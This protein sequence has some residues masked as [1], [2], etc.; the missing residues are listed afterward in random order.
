M[1]GARILGTYLMIKLADGNSF[2]RP[3]GAAAQQ[4]F[5]ELSGEAKTEVS[6]GVCGGALQFRNARLTA[7]DTGEKRKR[8]P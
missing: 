7:P 1:G 4:L 5:G 8:C 6:R 2:G 3:G